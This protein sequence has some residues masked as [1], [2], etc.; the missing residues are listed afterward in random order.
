MIDQKKIDRIMAMQGTAH[1]YKCEVLTADGTINS[2][3]GFSFRQMR[4]W[5]VKEAKQVPQRM[6]RV[7]DMT[8]GEQV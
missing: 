4:N 2:M 3:T 8:T 6:I 5:L 7:T 1:R